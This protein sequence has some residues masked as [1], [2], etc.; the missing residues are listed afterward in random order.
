VRVGFEDAFRYLGERGFDPE[1]LMRTI[2]CYR[3]T[4]LVLVPTMIGMLLNHSSFGSYDLSSVQR[5][6]YGASPMPLPLLREAMQKLP[7]VEFS[8]GYGMT[9]GSA[10]FTVLQWEDHRLEN[11]DRA[12]APVK[13]AGKPVM[14]VEIRVVD[15]NDND[16]PVETAGEIIARGPNI[17][18]GYWNRPEITAE[19]LRGGWMH[20]GDMGAYD[21]EG[22]L[23]ILDRKK[24]MIKT[25]SENVYSP[26]VESAMCGHPAVLEAAA[27]GVPDSQ[28][29]E[30]VRA[31]VAL[32]P[33][34]SLT[35]EELMEW[36]R[37]RLTHFKCPTSVV[38]TDTL[39]KGGTGKVQKNA[40]RERFG[41]VSVTAAD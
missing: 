37:G 14:G 13:S 36:C 16:V 24:D 31:V 18:K 10:L 2:E 35:A 29:G 25:G 5:L 28:W 23:Y 20:T 15:A 33:G 8:Q 11:T 41:A 22:F 32:R 4:H 26:E 1:N 40:L 38:F 3:I 7:H 34:A 27:I 12:F 6:A 30:S 17:M 21:E 19:V 9:E 39:P